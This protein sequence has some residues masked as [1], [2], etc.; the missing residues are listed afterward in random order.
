MGTKYLLVLRR[1]SQTLGV[2][3][4]PTKAG[5]VLEGGSGDAG[6]CGYQ[7]LT[8]CMG[9]SKMD[10]CC[11]IY[12]YIEKERPNWAKAVTASVDIRKGYRRQIQFS[13]I[14]RNLDNNGVA[15]LSHQDQVWIIPMENFLDKATDNNRTQARKQSLR[16]GSIPL[17]IRLQLRDNTAW[18][19]QYKIIS[20]TASNFKLFFGW[21]K[22][23]YVASDDTLTVEWGGEYDCLRSA[24]AGDKDKDKDDDS[25]DDNKGTGTN[26]TCKI[27]WESWHKI[28]MICTSSYM[29]S[30]MNVSIINPNLP[31]I[32]SIMIECM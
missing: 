2:F 11:G 23:Q 21:E 18:L 22:L 24:R 20:M 30:E 14:D 5:G 32:F 29:I 3:N 9:W 31:L 10:H 7:A 26:G 12:I 8:V 15:I 4:R 19:S 16:T 1:H 17:Q 28:C 25:N 6:S 13:V 27:V